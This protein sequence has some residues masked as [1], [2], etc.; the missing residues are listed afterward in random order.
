MSG[1]HVNPESNH[2]TSDDEELVHSGQKTT[3][4]T[5]SVFRDVKRVDTG[6]SADT[7]TGD[8]ATDEDGGEFTER[9]SLHGDTDEDDGGNGDETPLATELVGE[10]GS[11]EGTNQTTGLEGR[12]DV[13]RQVGGLNLGCVLQT[14]VTVDEC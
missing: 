5:R 14:V 9:S 1:T 12:D 8:E 11:G 4:C 13:A 3:D 2:S 7:E 10:L 6:G